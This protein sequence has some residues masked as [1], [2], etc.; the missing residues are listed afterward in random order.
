MYAMPSRSVGILYLLGLGY[1]GLDL[2]D[3]ITAN[4]T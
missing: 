2:F 1:G 4:D 3:Y